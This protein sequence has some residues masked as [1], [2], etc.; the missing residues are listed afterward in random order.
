MKTYL[1]LISI[2]FLS[3]NS[4]K[5]TFTGK[6][7]YKTTI[8]SNNGNQEDYNYYLNKYGDTLIIDYMKNGD[9]KR[10]HLNGFL[11]YQ[12]YKAKE[13][14]VYFKYQN[15]VIDTFP[16][17]EFSLEKVYKKRIK[18]E[19]IIGEN[20]NCF[21]LLS[22]AKSDRD[23][24]YIEACY[25]ENKSKFFVNYKLYETYKDYYIYELFK[26]N[27]VPYLKYYIHYPE[28]TIKY[29]GINIEK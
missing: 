21:E 14:A 10:K 17:Y 26:Q 5:S 6:V 23:S 9:M 19:Q 4:C 18:D 20:C 12:L 15:S 29:D 24:V 3:L 8:I 16:C 22:I 25:P 7:T 2:I 1:I 27:E 13:G 11:D 28:V